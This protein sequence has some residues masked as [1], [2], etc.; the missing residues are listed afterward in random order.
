MEG[1]S[2]AMKE[3]PFS[4]KSFKQTDRLCKEIDGK[5]ALYCLI[6]S[7]VGHS[8]SPQMYN[9]AFRRWGIHAVYLAFDIQED[10]IAEAISAVRLLG[11]QGMNVTMPC[12]TKIL[13]YL[14]DLSMEAKLCGAV[15]TVVKEGKGLKGYMTD[16]V[17]FAKN[18]LV[19][20]CSIRDKKVTL[21]GSGGAGRAIQMQIVKEGARSLSIFKRKN[22]TFA[23][24]EKFAAQMHSLSNSCRIQ[25]LDL[26]DQE[27]FQKEVKD[28]DL[29]VNATNVGMAPKVE[30]SILLEN[31]CFHKDLTVAD[32]VYHPDE[33][34]LLR[35]AREEGC[36]VI[37]GRGMLLK[38]GEEAFRL[39]TGL[40]VTWEERDDG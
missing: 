29:L 12:K 16:G 18:L 31:S 3:D 25:V 38:Q 10:Q 35:K 33:T 34:R 7:P 39:F 40:S 5:T 24:Q 4:P 6:G 17:G 32:I 36:K 2:G 37:G 1:K 21:C 11:I 15:N 20:G 26:A 19:H 22:H 28:S 9:E 23:A 8:A 14:D 13:P 30:E 27:L